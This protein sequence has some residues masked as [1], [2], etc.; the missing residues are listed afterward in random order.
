MEQTWLRAAPCH[1]NLAASVGKKKRVLGRLTQ[2]A[3]LALAEEADGL[4]TR[5]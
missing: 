5:R 3:A 4:P 1:A 2:P